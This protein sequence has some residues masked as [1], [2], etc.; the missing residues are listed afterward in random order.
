M[1][2]TG[3]APTTV[4]PQSTATTAPVA[5][6]MVATAT[7]API[8]PKTLATATEVTAPAAG[9][10]TPDVIANAERTLLKQKAWRVT[11]SIVAS[12]G[13]TMTTQIE[14]V[15][16]DRV[17]FVSAN[18]EWIAIKGVGAWQKTAGAQWQQAPAAMSSVGDSLFLAMDPAQIDQMM[19]IIV[20]EKFKSDGNDMLSGKPMRVYEYATTMTLGDTTYNG[21]SKIWIG[22]LDGLPYKSTGSTTS[23]GASG[24]TS[25]V[26]TSYQYDS[27]IKIEAPM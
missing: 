5:P 14:Y 21:T 6:T 16:P 11:T 7:A 20:V 22:A 19:N 26:T 18:G 15:T 2:L 12:D 24:G 25:E 3:A 13:V 17:H 27:G 4:A 10:N 23:G 1:P 8:A 9:G